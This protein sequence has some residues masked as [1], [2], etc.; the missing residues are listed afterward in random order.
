LS[1]RRRSDSLFQR[2]FKINFSLLLNSAS[3][4]IFRR[5]SYDERADIKAQA[6]QKRVDAVSADAA[7][8]RWAYSLARKTSE[9][10]QLLAMAAG[11]S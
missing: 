6:A 2:K 3:D 7:Y 1:R 9:V 4:G 10:K 5:D 8:G 11:Q